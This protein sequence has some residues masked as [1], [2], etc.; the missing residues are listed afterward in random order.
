ML[1]PGVISLL[2]LMS[3]ATS[4]NNQLISSLQFTREALMGFFRGSERTEEMTVPVSNAT[5]TTY[6][7]S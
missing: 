1:L 4:T 2:F 6:R 5:T 3:V 7:V